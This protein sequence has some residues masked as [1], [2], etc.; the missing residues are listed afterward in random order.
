LKLVKQLRFELEAR[1][2][3]VARLNAVLE[4]RDHALGEISSEKSRERES[5]VIELRDVSALFE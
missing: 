4:K 5:E 3:E 1:E 2:D